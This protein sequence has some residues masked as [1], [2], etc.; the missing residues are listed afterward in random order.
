[1]A[2][3]LLQEKFWISTDILDLKF[4]TWLYKCLQKPHKNTTES[5]NLWE[6]KWQQEVKNAITF[7][8]K[9]TEK[10]RLMRAVKLSKRFVSMLMFDWLEMD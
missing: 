3:V 9:S 1:M 6:E 7:F 5:F 2:D 8:S 10:H 4:S